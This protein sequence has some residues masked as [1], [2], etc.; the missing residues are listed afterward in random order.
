M[1]R[2]APSPAQPQAN[3]RLDAA[4]AWLK[5]AVMDWQDGF[6][7]EARQAAESRIHLP[8]KNAGSSLGEMTARTVGAL[9]EPELHLTIPLQKMLARGAT[10][11]AEPEDESQTPEALEQALQ[12]AGDPATWPT[13]S[14]VIPI[15]WKL[16][17]PA[18]KIG[19]A[20]RLAEELS[21]ATG[22]ENGTC[23]AG[24]GT[25]CPVLAS[26]TGGLIPATSFDW[27]EGS[28]T[29]SL[30]G[31]ALAR[32]WP[33]KPSSPV[34]SRERWVKRCGI[35]PFMFDMQPSDPNSSSWLELAQLSTSTTTGE[36]GKRGIRIKI[37]DGVAKGS[38]AKQPT[39]LENK[40][41]A[42][43]GAA[44]S[45]PPA[46]QKPQQKHQPAG[47]GRPQASTGATTPAAPAKAAGG[48]PPVPAP[49][50]AGQPAGGLGLEEFFGEDAPLLDK[51]RLAFDME[52]DPDDEPTDPKQMAKQMAI[53]MKVL[54]QRNKKKMEENIDPEFRNQEPEAPLGEEEEG[55]KPKRGLS[56]FGRSS[57]QKDQIEEEEL[58]LPE[59]EED[60]E[61]RPRNKGRRNPLMPKK[62]ARRQEQEQSA[63][64]EKLDEV[65]GR[66]PLRIRIL[67]IVVAA[68]IAMMLIFILIAGRLGS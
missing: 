58:D 62:K 24:G 26:P 49:G 64:A 45:A 52:A 3:R 18:E 66:M 8:E 15:I 1:N 59:Q 37:G 54:Q 28:R 13:P 39:N 36:M 33:R 23:E 44:R 21:E 40:P 35:S 9:A 51:D 25:I 67:S 68:L 2:E 57:R 22:M 32:I 46:A 29:L 5:L 56:P 10:F 38:P 16:D 7:E 47:S 4:P 11:L 61:E 6:R 43:K 27:D 55:K 19:M 42:A 17:L 60:E 31:T 30:T 20:E 34:M 50:A 48:K 53:A 65:W 12:E 63:I 41:A 14:M